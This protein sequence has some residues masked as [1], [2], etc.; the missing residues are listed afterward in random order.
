MVGD[1]QDHVKVREVG[2][3]LGEYGGELT[4]HHDRPSV[5]I[6]EQISQFFRD[7]S[8]VD[9]ERCNARFQRTQHHLEVFVSVVEVDT[10]M[11]LPADVAVEIAAFG[12]AAQASIEERVG[13]PPSALGHLTPRETMIAKDEARVVGP[14]R[15]NC[16]VNF[17]KADGD[18]FGG[19]SVRHGRLDQT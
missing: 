6:V 18:R 1:L 15:R 14:G 4:V 12:V 2:Q 17:G 19:W 13:Q 5:R 7:V 10:N 8:V 3:D 9:V 16:L 11:I